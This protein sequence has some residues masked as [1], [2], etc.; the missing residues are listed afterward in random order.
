MRL[1]DFFGVVGMILGIVA[2]VGI[3][4]PILAFGAWWLHTCFEFFFI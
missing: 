2:I 4:C 3:A 1:E